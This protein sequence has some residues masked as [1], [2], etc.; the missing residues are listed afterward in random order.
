MRIVQAVFGVF[1]HFELARELDRRGQLERV[2]S[3]WPWSRLKR[4]G[5]P[6]AKVETFPWLHMPEY[7]LHRAAIDWPWATDH[8]GYANA[9]AFD[10]WT[11]RCIP[12]CDALIAISGAGLLTGRRVQQRGGVFICDRGSTHQ[13]FQQQIIA[14]EYR[15]WGVGRAVSDP[16]DTAREELIYAQADAI[17]V[18]SA[19]AA[20]SFAAMGVPAEKV[21]VIPYGVRLEDFYPTAEPA[22][23][24]FDVLFAGAAGLRKGV[25]YLL[26]AFAELRHPRKRLRIAGAILPDLKQVLGR[27]PQEHVEFLGAVPQ[28]RLRD[29]MSASHALVL[30]SIEEG[31]ALVQAQAMACGCPVICSTNTGGE[32][33]F[34]DGVAG[35]IVPIRDPAALTARMQQ[36]ADDPALRQTIRA[37]AL[38]RVRS[39]GGWSDY[40]DRWE[41]LLFRLT[42]T[43]SPT[44]ES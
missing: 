30:P 22:P 4:E 28:P 8:L 43:T 38:Q 2:Y 14:E 9:L 27:L 32:D 7:L 37:A 34:T 18:P 26:Q 31:L 25:P 13:R 35:F 19:A 10:R 21:H 3:T 11:D 33:L 36:L 6:H 15:I 16:R 40:G 24:R 29:L 39:I 44:K 17:T 42:G 1:H 20:R 41:Q 23:G 12:A 5:L